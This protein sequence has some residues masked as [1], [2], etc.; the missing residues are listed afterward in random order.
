MCCA[1]L[2]EIVKARAAHS[3]LF[4]HSEAQHMDEWFGWTDAIW[5]HEDKD[6]SLRTMQLEHWEQWEGQGSWQVN[7]RLM[8]SLETQKQNFY[9]V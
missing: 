9:C 4:F 5:D 2:L 6:G 1:V 7:P 8:A 3:Y